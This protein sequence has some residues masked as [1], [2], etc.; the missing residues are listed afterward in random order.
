MTIAE[1][2][3]EEIY[4]QNGLVRSIPAEWIDDAV[5]KSNELIVEN[6]LMKVQFE[7]GRTQQGFIYAFKHGNNKT[8][9]IVSYSNSLFLSCVC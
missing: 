7:N 1:L 8:E 6:E 2:F 4:S 5:I 3:Q 9:E